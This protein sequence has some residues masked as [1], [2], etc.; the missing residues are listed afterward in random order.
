MKEVISMADDRCRQE[1][2]CGYNYEM[3]GSCELSRHAM[4]RACP[5]LDAPQRRVKD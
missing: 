1:D 5:L 2:K 3:K 4:W